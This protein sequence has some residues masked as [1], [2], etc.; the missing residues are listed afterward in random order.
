MRWKEREGIERLHERYLRWVMRNTAGYIVREEIQRKKLKG[1]AGLRAWR[2][3]KKLE[4]RKGG[5]LA[6]IC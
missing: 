4:E 3:E 1:R 6:R 5:E 2:Y